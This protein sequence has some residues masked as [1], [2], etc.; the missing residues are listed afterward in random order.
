MIETRLITIVECDRCV[1]RVEVKAINVEYNF[2]QGLLA[3]QKRAWDGRKAEGW[4][5]PTRKE[6]ALAHLCPKCSQEI[7]GEKE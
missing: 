1:D 7:G 5:E 2:C 3:V 4:T 6:F